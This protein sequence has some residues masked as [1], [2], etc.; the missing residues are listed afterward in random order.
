MLQKVLKNWVSSMRLKE[1]VSA[2]IS[3][4]GKKGEFAFA[5]K[6]LLSVFGGV[7]FSQP[8]LSMSLSPFAPSFAAS[9]PPVLSLCASAGASLG[10]FMFHSGTSAFRYFSITLTSAA[11]LIICLKAFGM[12]REDMVRPLCPGLCSFAVNT[13]FCFAFI[14]R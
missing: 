12:K 14:I 10:F 13:V 11:S 1:R 6:M 3:F 8:Y 7:L 2:A 4:E 5:L 9:L